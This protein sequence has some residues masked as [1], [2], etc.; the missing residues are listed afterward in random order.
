MT[1]VS[2]LPLSW[3]VDGGTPQS[4]V[5]RASHPQSGSLRLLRHDPCSLAAGV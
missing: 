2:A 3:V 4:G 5:L 1:A